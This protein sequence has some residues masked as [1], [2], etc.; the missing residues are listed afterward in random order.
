VV[1]VLSG[2]ELVFGHAWQTWL[3]PQAVCS[4]WR[5]LADQAA[6]TAFKER[7]G[8]RTIVGKPRNPAALAVRLAHRTGSVLR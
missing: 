8:L 5:D 6:L 4:H 7:W 3:S 1:L 2:H